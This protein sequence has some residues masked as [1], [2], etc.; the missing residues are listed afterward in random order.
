MNWP[1]FLALPSERVTLSPLALALPNRTATK[2]IRE[3]PCCDTASQIALSLTSRIYFRRVMALRHGR[4]LSAH[5]ASP[6]N[7]IFTILTVMK[8]PVLDFAALR[9]L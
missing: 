4:C 6:F 5:A 9:F 2:N 8:M 7:R 3:E 1:V